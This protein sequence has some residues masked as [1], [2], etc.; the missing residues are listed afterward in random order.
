M[1]ATKIRLVQG[2][3]AP[4]L[5]LSLTDERTG[6]PIDVSDAG[7]S[8][9]VLF[10]EVGSDEVKAT[11]SAYPIAGYQNPETQEIEFSPPYTVPGRG[12]RVVMQWSPTALDTAGEFEAEVETQLPDGRVQTAFGILRFQVREQF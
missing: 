1:A 6:L 7:T 3:T 2:D 11:L 12:G 10:R 5:I 9:R 4:N 8:V